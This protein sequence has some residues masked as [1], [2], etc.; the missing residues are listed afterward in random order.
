MI[1][2]VPTNKENAPVGQKFEQEMLSI[3]YRP[4]STQIR[5]I[6]KC[7]K[8]RSTEFGARVNTWKGLDHLENGNYTLPRPLLPH[9]ESL[10]SGAVL[11]LSTTELLDVKWGGGTLRQW[12]CNVL[13][14]AESRGMLEV[15]IWHLAVYR[16]CSGLRT[17]LLTWRSFENIMYSF[18]DRAW[19]WT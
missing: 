12:L 9:L 1:T 19:R 6:S 8:Q 17:V 5:A 15:I 7:Y 13:Q 16:R 11:G 14:E 2:F 4:P 10:R 3:H 18:G